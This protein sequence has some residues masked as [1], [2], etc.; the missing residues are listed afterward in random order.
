MSDLKV[1][2]RQWYG[3]DRKGGKNAC[4][5]VW[6]EIIKMFK[7]LSERELFYW[8]CLQFQMIN[9]SRDLVV[10]NAVERNAFC[11]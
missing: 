3:Q 7:Q 10:I 5:L 2:Q 8:F 1:I 11:A 9:H 4:K 6:N